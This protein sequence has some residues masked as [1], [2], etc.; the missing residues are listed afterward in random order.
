MAGSGASTPPVTPPTESS[1]IVA[2]PPVTTPPAS[3][4]V[5]ITPPL[6]V[7]PAATVTSL[8]P[9][10]TAA[11]KFTGSSNGNLSGSSNISTVDVHSLLYAGNTTR[12][13]AHYTPWWGLQVRGVTVNYNSDSPSQALATFASMSDRGVNGVVLDWYGM[14]NSINKTWLD[15]LSSLAQFPK[16]TFSIMFDEGIQREGAC[17]GCG[18]TQ[19][20]LTNLDY[21]AQNYFTNPQYEKYN[22]KYVVTE[23]AVQETWPTV[24]WATIQAAHPEVYWI[25]QHAPEG[26]AEV[27]SAG[28]YAWIDA[29][30]R[31]AP[32]PI[33]A[34][35]SRL[36]SFNQYAVA[37]LPLIPISG[38]WKGFDDTLASWADGANHYVP[39]ACG[40]TWLA[41][42]ANAN[43]SFS[44][45][46]QL[47]FLQLITWNDYEEGSALE[48]GIE[49]CSTV[50]ATVN[51]Q[52]IT[53]SLVHQETVDH[54]EFY[55]QVTD[56]YALLGTYAANVTSIAAPNAGTYFIKAVGKPFMQNIASSEIVI[57]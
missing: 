25:H 31:V 18:I 23:F 8:L 7:L 48:P 35:L 4:P 33:T 17:T 24:D 43:A 15:S 26:Y 47:P 9:G 36:S 1:P 37:H 12:V 50:S 40:S 28:G 22:G 11:P 54:L 3:S 53:V 21:V 13:L 51:K 34:D 6:T 2:A 41:T 16:M 57:Q 14:T 42:F 29:P 38:A 49:T 32:L 19:T 10:N 46:K 20:I 45:A 56:G 39:Q 55:E 5:V 44:A 52:A 30:N 27:D